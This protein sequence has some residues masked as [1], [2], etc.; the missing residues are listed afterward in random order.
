M[1]TQIEIDN[2]MKRQNLDNAEFVVRQNYWVDV[3]VNGQY[4]DTAV[5][6]FG[7]KAKAILNGAK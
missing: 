7:A 3:Y 2:Y 1:T 6:K 4:V 5:G